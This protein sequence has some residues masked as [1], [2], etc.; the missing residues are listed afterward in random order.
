[1]TFLVHGNTRINVKFRHR[2]EVL[3]SNYTVVSLWSKFQFLKEH[4]YS[5][6]AVNRLEKEDNPGRLRMLK[7]ELKQ[8]EG[9]M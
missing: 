5:F 7:C 4:F 9:Q 3:P 6:Q 8:V 2:A 1:M